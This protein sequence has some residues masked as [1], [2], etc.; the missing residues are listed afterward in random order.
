MICFSSNVS[1]RLPGRA[2]NNR[3]EIHVNFYRFFYV[4]KENVK[5]LIHHWN[6]FC[7]WF[8]KDSKLGKYS[9]YYILN[10]C[11]QQELLWNKPKK[12]EWEVL[13]LWQIANFLS[14]VSCQYQH[15]YHV[16]AQ[17][18]RY[19]TD[20]TVY[21]LLIFSGITSWIHKWKKNGWTLSDNTKV[22][23][24]EDWKSLDS[25]MQGIDVKFVRILVSTVSSVKSVEY[26][27]KNS[28]STDFVQVVHTVHNYEMPIYHA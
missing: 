25:E 17:F 27:I 19:R 3:A 15:Y 11:R 23:N 4:C 21:N 12:R 20:K 8:V 13:R 7:L 9:K 28:W 5:W 2:T 6:Y 18:D 10:F 22:K 14:M 1:E 26:L 24:E 16:T